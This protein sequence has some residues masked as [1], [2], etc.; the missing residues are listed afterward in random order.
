MKCR[1][2]CPKKYTYYLYGSKSSDTGWLLS[3]FITYELEKRVHLRSNVTHQNSFARMYAKALNH[4]VNGQCNEFIS[5]WLKVLLSFRY[6][7]LSASHRKSLLAEVK[8]KL[9]V[10]KYYVL[11]TMC[12]MGASV[13]F[14]RHM[15][16][17]KHHFDKVHKIQ[18]IKQYMKIA[19]MI[20]IQ[21]SVF[22]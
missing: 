17:Q 4:S 8:Y 10:R 16:T 1:K 2:R 21:K 6:L 22:F 3:H 20:M 7:F 13:W 14:M 9:R 11:V 5:R 12:R 18:N 15:C 19:W